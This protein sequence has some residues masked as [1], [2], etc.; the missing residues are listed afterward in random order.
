MPADD[1]PAGQ[2]ATVTFSYRASD[3][4]AESGTAS[5]QIQ[6]VNHPP[7]VPTQELT[8]REDRGAGHVIGQVA[9]TDP[10][11]GQSHSF[12]I[13]AGDPTDL[14]DVDAAGTLC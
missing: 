9:F 14:F 2:A 12:A 10:D 4:R 7:A 1:L 5:V 3:G 6:G 13:A 11:P 8:V